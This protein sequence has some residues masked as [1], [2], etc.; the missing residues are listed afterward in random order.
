MVNTEE[1]SE[2]IGKIWKKSKLNCDEIWKIEKKNQL[3]SDQIWKIQKT[4]LN[5]FGIYRRKQ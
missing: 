2:K 1:N 3:N 5:R 4:I